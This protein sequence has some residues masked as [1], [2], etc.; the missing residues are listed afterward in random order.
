LQH[1]Y[2][3][4]FRPAWDFVHSVET[5][6]LLN[7]YYQNWKRKRKWDDSILCIVKKINQ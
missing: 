6:H 1:A 7:K 3:G 4:T 2:Y 5:T